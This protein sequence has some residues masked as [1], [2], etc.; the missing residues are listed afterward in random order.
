MTREEITSRICD[1]LNRI[2]RQRAVIAAIKSDF[3]QSESFKAF[4][5]ALEA[6]KAEL[7]FCEG[8]LAEFRRD[9]AEM[10]LDE[11]A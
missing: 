10:R 1:A 6:A 4:D 2:D 9:A 8:D 11:V 5:K 7:R 3:K